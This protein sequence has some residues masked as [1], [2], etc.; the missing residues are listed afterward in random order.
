MFAFPASA[1]TAEYFVSENGT[2]LSAHI[3]LVNQSEFY[4]VKPGIFGSDEPLKVD[5][6]SLKDAEGNDI[7]YK[8]SDYTL[9]F[10]KG[11]YTLVYKS[12]ITDNLIYAKYPDKYNVTA[13]I[14]KQ[15]NTGHLILGT[16]STGG[17]ITELTS[18]HAVS[19]IGTKAISITFFDANRPLILYLFLGIWAVVMIVVLVRHQILKK[20]VRKI[21]E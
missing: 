12:K 11:N 20:R 9:K 17:V 6:L 10:E 4:L 13:F 2:G 5:E 19:Y 15:F 18:G 8:Q 16:V 21:N 14:P 3:T 7:D 1:N